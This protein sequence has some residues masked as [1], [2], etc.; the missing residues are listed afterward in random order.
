MRSALFPALFPALLSAFLPLGPLAA[1]QDAFVMLRGTD[2]IAVEVFRRLPGRL[3]VDLSE[4]ITRSR[5]TFALERTPEGLVHR[6][7]NELRRAD[8]ATGSPPQQQAVLTFQSDSVIVEITDATGTR[9]QRLGTRADALPYVN[10]STA[11]VELLLQRAHALGGDSATVPLFH[12]AGGMTLPTTVRWLGADSAL[13]TFAP[14]Q[15]FRLA[16][17]AEQRILGG[18]VP[19]QGLRVIRTTLPVD[20]VFL[21]PPDYAAPPDAPYTA[22]DVTVPTPM[23]HTLAGTLTVPR[24]PGPWPAVVTISG[25]GSQD[26]DQEIPLVKGFRPFRQIAD[27]L[28]RMGIAVLRMDDRGFGLSGGH[29][30]TATSADFA[31]DIA[32]GV[33]FLRAHPDVDPDQIFLVGHSEGGLIAPMVAAAD[34]RIRGIV[35]MA[36]P[37]RTG[38]E[39]LRFQNGYAIERSAAILPEARDSA[40]VAAMQG[41]DSLAVTNPWL[42]FFLDHDPLAV[43]E[44][45]RAPVLLLQGATDRQVTA[46]QADALGAAFRTGGNEDVTVRVFPEINHLFLRDPSGDPSGYGALP[47]G[48]LDREV[49]RTLTE[50]LRARM[51]G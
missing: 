9:T 23:G 7:E 44:R 22:T 39:I 15:E 46:E 49:I 32:A 40:L 24:G 12:L 11:V 19:S 34:P 31:R 14:G 6:L 5:L 26:R 41:V 48:E 25:S 20:A 50:W 51:A 1:Q 18:E 16:V 3:D 21:P 10:P 13:V 8:A 38:R 42:R 47:T 28:G 43:A 2:T 4:R 33:A 17:D 29:A 37:A 30:A 27:T 36:G 35:L 45:V